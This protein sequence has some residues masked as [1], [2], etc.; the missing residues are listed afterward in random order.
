MVEK[1][2][3]TAESGKRVSD[4]GSPVGT[5]LNGLDLRTP[6]SGHSDE[7]Q[8]DLME[9][10]DSDSQALADVCCEL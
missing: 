5:T 9:P 3:R 8:L 1:V 4:F 10:V 2:K 6:K 7:T